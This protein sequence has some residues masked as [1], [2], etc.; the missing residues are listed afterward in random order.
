M[1]DYIIEPLDTDAESIY[2]DFVEHVRGFYP[3]WNPSEAQLDVII[4]RFFSQQTATVAD[5]ASR[6]QRAIYRYMG[7]YLENIPPLEGTPAGGTIQFHLIDS[8]QHTMD[9]GTYIGIADAN[10]DIQRFQTLDDM[11]V[12]EGSP[13]PTVNIQAVDE[14]AQGNGL[15]GPVQLLEQFDWIESGYV[16]GYTSGGSDD[17][18]DDVYIQ[19]MTDNLSIPRRPAYASDLEI[20]ARNIPGVWR[21]A[22]LDN[23]EDMGGGSWAPNKE[24][25][26]AI[27]AVDQNGEVIPDA[28]RDQLMEYL[29]Q[30]LRQN[31]LLTWV[32]PTYNVID[33]M[34]AAHAWPG[35]GDSETVETQVEDNLRVVL[36]PATAGQQTGSNEGS[37]TI[38][39]WV[40][41]PIMRYLELT[42]AVENARPI[43][44]L[45]T[46]SFR[47]NGGAYNPNDKDLNGIFPMTRMGNIDGTIFTP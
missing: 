6:V 42:T 43:N 32:P 37:S 3:D 17:E 11:F 4:P 10:G 39:S 22:A 8:G 24:D 20:M 36:D 23:F 31:F 40:T 9:A 13:D 44:Y 18:E 25:S 7:A 29:A 47:V 28:V 35:S 27:S 26:V 38:R 12:P 46:L 33:V 5:M 45:A 2:R 41:V 21:A 34:Y 30:N 14:G 15:S 19:R 1:A 16:V